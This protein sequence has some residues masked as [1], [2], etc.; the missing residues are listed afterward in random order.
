MKSKSLKRMAAALSF[1]AACCASNSAFAKDSITLMLNYTVNGAVAP[2]YLG[3]VKGYYD[4]EGIDLKLMEG[5][6][7][8]PTV[9]AV[10][11]HNVDI[12]YADFSTM[13]KV[14]AM[15][16]PVKAIGVLMQENP[17]SVVGLAEKNI[18]TP[19]DIKGKTVAVAPGDASSQLWTMF[20]NKV[21]LKDSDFKTITGNPQTTINAVITG[22]ADLLVGFA[23]IP[24]ISVEQ[25][26]KKPAHALL[27][28]DYQVNVA[29]LSI[30]ARDDM[31]KNNADLLKRFMRATAK[32]VAD[33]E[34]DPAA[35]VDALL[36]TLP[37]A[38]SRDTMIRTLKATIPFYRTP[39]TENAPIFHVS[40]KNI[41]DSVAAVVRYSK[42]DPAANVPAKYYTSAFV[43]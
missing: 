13:I 1:A 10:A 34:K 26:T 20:M 29:T 28:A 43:P 35:A 24:L 23:T 22:Q 37:A 14:A 21:G 4:A 11:T 30:I 25:A 9:Q 3:K 32:S 8:G 18:K 39:E 7:S 12:G 16:A 38:G 36:K 40:A 31:I 15:G 2:F 42:L 33:S 19:Q 27:F 5:H 17:T 6:G 41:D